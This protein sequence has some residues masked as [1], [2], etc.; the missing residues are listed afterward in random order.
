MGGTG[1]RQHAD[2]EELS[3]KRQGESDDQRGHKR[4]QRRG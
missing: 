1:H 4:V 3:A 2:T